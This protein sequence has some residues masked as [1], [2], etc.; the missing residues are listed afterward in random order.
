MLFSI[1]VRFL[2]LI[3]ALLSYWT[4][5]KSS[6]SKME[7]KAYHWKRSGYLIPKVCHHCRVCHNRNAWF[8]VLTVLEEKRPWY[9][10]GFLRGD[11]PSRKLIAKSEEDRTQTAKK[12]QL[13]VLPN[14]LEYIY[15]KRVMYDIAWK[16]FTRLIY[17]KL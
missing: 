7:I 17:L 4:G 6:I 12:A 13:P 1:S 10:W 8:F 16:N 9:I 15:I 2:S 3:T 5:A 11:N 14:R